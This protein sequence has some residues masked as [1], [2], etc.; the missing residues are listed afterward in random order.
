MCLTAIRSN[1]VYLLIVPLKVK[2]KLEFFDIGNFKYLLPESYPLETKW[3]DEM[4]TPRKAETKNSDSHTVEI[5][6]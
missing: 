6:K 4:N 2:K 1:I 5:P 3:M